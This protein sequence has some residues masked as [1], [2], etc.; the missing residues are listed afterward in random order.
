MGNTKTLGIVSRRVPAA[1]DTVFMTA[2]DAA[3]RENGFVSP[4]T[5]HTI[6]AFK[7]AAVPS[8]IW[9]RP[10]EKVVVV[11]AALTVALVQVAVGVPVN[12]G[13]P[14]TEIKATGLTASVP[15][16]L[17]VNV[18]A[19]DTTLLLNS[20][21][22]Y[23]STLFN[24]ATITSTVN[25]DL[26][27]NVLNCLHDSDSLGLVRFFVHAHHACCGMDGCMA[28]RNTGS[29][30]L[31]SVDSVYVGKFDRVLETSVD[32]KLQLCFGSNYVGRCED[33]HH[34]AA[35]AMDKNFAKNQFLKNCFI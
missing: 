28:A 4:V 1:A 31:E 3:A 19:T 27:F 7:V 9:R 11:T 20:I 25:N 17:T 14:V 26:I 29:R 34:H 5:E 32:P 12:D 16:K 24:S 23:A 18:A 35:A 13:K 30:S 15:V 8:V 21:R 6:A 33:P 10:A 22:S 2:V